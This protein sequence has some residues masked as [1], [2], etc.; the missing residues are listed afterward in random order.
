MRRVQIHAQPTPGASL[1]Q[2]HESGSRGLDTGLLVQE[3][4]AG[5]G[6]VR[7]SPPGRGVRY[8]VVLSWK[9]S[10]ELFGSSLRRAG[11]ASFDAGR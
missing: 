8:R 1:R 4:E 3:S 5:V 11:R 2:H 9:D 7:G 6:V 10:R